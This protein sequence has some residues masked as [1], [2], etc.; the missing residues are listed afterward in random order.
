MVTTLQY[1]KRLDAHFNTFVLRE[2][3]PSS[4]ASTRPLNR[5][6]RLEQSLTSNYP[7]NPTNKDSFYRYRLASY[8]LTDGM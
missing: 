2:D 4:T 6:I 7:I 1:V 8:G 3:Y 5:V